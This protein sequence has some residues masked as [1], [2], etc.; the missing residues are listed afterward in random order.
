MEVTF[1]YDFTTD[2]K[3]TLQNVTGTGVTFNQNTKQFTIGNK[4]Y[5]ATLDNDTVTETL[6]SGA[7][8]ETLAS[9][10]FVFVKV[11]DRTAFQFHNLNETG[12]R[13]GITITKQ[14]D[15]SFKILFSDA[16]AL[17]KK[18]LNITTTATYT[19][20]VASTLNP[21]WQNPI[22]NITG[23][24]ATLTAAIGDGYEVQ[25]NAVV[26]IKETDAAS[27]FI[28][29]FNFRQYKQRRNYRHCRSRY[30]QGRR[31]R[32]CN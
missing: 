5:S 27:R 8:N 7:Y 13:D 29:S 25:S 1:T 16:A 3:G 24:A 22:W 32:R 20:E 6:E 10:E 14:D 4:T 21:A 19:V 11:T 30:N 9:G 31:G 28:S 12:S 23:T 17:D 15:D 26:Y 18:S 2:T